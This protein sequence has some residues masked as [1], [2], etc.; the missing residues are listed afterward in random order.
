MTAFYIHWN[1]S[2][3][4][5]SV[6]GVPL[7][8]Y[9]FLFMIGVLLSIYVLYLIFKKE[10]IPA[11]HLEKLFYGGMFG[12]LLGARLG[13][14]L[15]YE[16]GYF[17][18]RPLEM[19]FP[20]AISPGGDITFIGYQG[21]A[22]HGGTLSLLLVFLIFSRWAKIPLLKT[23]D[24]VAVV[25]PL[26]AGFIRLGNLMNSEIIGKITTA[27]WAFIFEQVDQQPRH[28]AQLYE[29]IAYLGIFCLNFFLYKKRNA[30]TQPGLL[31]GTSTA[32]VFTARFVLEFVKENQTSAEQEM[33]FN[34]GQW[35]SIPFILL[36]LGFILRANIKQKN[37]SLA[38]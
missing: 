29:A 6:A 12:G 8:Y 28:P 9:G 35:L 7:R 11:G 32:L 34:M 24:M 37:T 18:S 5:F 2:L 21:L 15:I 16:P 10:S 22:S 38:L 13:H 19:L 3:E 26:G 36:G 20:I 4:L 17:L 14:C 27:P 31:F 30:I 1:P 33:L 23:L 25:G